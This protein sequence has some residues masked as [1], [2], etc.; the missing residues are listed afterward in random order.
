ME[1]SPLLTII[2]VTFQA[3]KFLGRTLQSVERALTQIKNPSQ[4]EYLI[5][6][7][8]SSDQTLSIASQYSR[9]ISK[10]ISEK[11]KGLYDAMNKGLRLATGKYVWFLNAGDEAYDDQTLQN[12]L[13]SLETGAGVYYSDAMMVREDG[14]EVGLR[15]RFTPHT[16][17]ANLRWQ[18]FALGMKA[19]HQA[20]IARK[21]IAPFYEYKNFSADIDWEIE[22]LKRAEKVAFLPFILCRY[23]LGGL[24]VKNHRRS[25]ID[26]YKVLK[27]HFGLIPTL[28]NHLRI[29]WRGYWFAKKNGKYW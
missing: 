23:L 4:L 3:E 26:R 5:I 21:D 11:D 12:L 22:C 17:P 7:G 8:G 1:N 25:L 16:L 15:S 6:D 20:F 27:K 28:F 2:T 9:F 24:S 14:T 29:F 19:C 13:S 18:D 10:I